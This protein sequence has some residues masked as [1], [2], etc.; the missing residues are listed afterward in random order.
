MFEK[1]ITTLSNP[2]LFYADK[3]GHAVFRNFNWFGN[4]GCSYDLQLSKI[5]V[6]KVL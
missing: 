4:C 6:G 2:I 5:E 1:I 3:E